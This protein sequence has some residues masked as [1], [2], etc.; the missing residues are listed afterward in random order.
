MILAAGRG[1]RLRPLT[2]RMPKP[3]I[4]VGGKALIV[5][6]LEALAGAGFDRVVVNLAWLGEQIEQTLGDGS[7]FG[8]SI[9]YSQEPPDALE[10]AGGIVQAL[11]L[12]GD[13]PFLMISGDVLCDYPLARLRNRPHQAQ[14]HLVMVDNPDHHP[15]GDFAID[16]DQ[17]L[18]HG[19]STQ[20][21]SGI[22]VLD[23]VLFA[24]L[25]PGRRPLRPVFEQAIALGRLTGEHYSGFW[26]DIGT[27]E[28]L[29]DAQRRLLAGEDRVAT[30]DRKRLHS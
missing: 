23:P 8:L 25:P 11:P 29:S 2:D 12:L 10:T 1:E 21:F 15:D 3:L 24:E 4:E 30:A 26:S 17:R 22:A 18:V 6:H 16:A 5:R 14:G 20:T 9:A 28:R 13:A 7:R 19:R 27:P